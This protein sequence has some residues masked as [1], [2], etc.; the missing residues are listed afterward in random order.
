MIKR[1]YV[2]KLKY[3]N[4]KNK[5]LLYKRKSTVKRESIDLNI[6]MFEYEYVIIISQI[7]PHSSTIL[8]KIKMRNDNTPP[9]SCPRQITLSK[10][11]KISR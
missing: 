2:F 1:S 4:D 8:Y 9:L 3:Q 10:I 5:Y 7:P 6:N 11:D